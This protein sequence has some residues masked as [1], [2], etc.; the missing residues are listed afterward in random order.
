MSLCRGVTS[1]DRDR[2]GL[3]GVRAAPVVSDQKK[4]DQK[5]GEG[6]EEME[7]LSLR[8]ESSQEGSRTKGEKK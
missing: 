3:S 4:G 2:G 6:V 8:S 1:E 7:A 5:R